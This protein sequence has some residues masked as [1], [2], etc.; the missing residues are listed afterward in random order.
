MEF[1]DKIQSLT[2]DNEDA[3]ET[4]SCEKSI[5]G[6]GI[7]KTKLKEI[8]TLTMV[9]GGYRMNTTGGDNEKH[10][11]FDREVWND[12]VKEAMYIHYTS[13]ISVPALET[14][15]SFIKK[16]VDKVIEDSNKSLVVH[17]LTKR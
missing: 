11:I 9:S 17:G 8:L 1:L 10:P 16:A 3:L 15:A 4:L 13:G 6:A 2:V 7:D 5:L 14:I 12:G